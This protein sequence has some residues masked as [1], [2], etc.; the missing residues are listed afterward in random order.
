MIKMFGMGQSR[1]LRC[2]NQ[3]VWW[4]ENQDVWGV[5]ISV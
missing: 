5:R 2:E 4:C 1:C 3:E